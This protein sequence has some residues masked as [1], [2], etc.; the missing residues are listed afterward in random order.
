[1]RKMD[2]AQAAFMFITSHWQQNHLSFWDSSFH[3][4]SPCLPHAPPPLPSSFL[5]PP[6]MLSRP[7]RAWIHRTNCWKTGQMV[8]SALKSQDFCFFS[9]DLA[10]EITPPSF[11]GENQRVSFTVQMKQEIIKGQVFST[12]ELSWS[13]DVWFYQLSK[14]AVMSPNKIG[15]RNFTPNWR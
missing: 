13:R 15:S 12:T 9:G 8:L 3:L 14:P 2:I 10:W 7:Q 11:H 5:S 6:H 1:M 4:A